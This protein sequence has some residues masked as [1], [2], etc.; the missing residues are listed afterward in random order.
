MTENTNR[1]VGSFTPRADNRIQPV[2]GWPLSLLGPLEAEH[3]GTLWRVMRRGPQWRHA[4]FAWLA[5]YAAESDAATICGAAERE[6]ADLIRA[7]FGAPAPDGLAGA[8][9]K[10]GFEPCSR[11]F[12]SNLREVLADRT[13]LG[14]RRAR[15]IKQVPILTE[16]MVD[17]IQTLNPH[18]CSPRVVA[19]YAHRSAAE[20]LNA[21]ARAVL[22]VCSGENWETIKLAVETEDRRGWPGWAAMKLARADRP[23]PE[24]LPTD[25]LPGARRVTPRNIEAI[26]AEFNNCLGGQ[27]AYRARLLSGRFAMVALAAPKVLVQMFLLADGTWVVTHVHLTKNADPSRALMEEVSG[28]LEPLGV[29]V[30]I[31]AP[32]PRQLEDLKQ[33]LSDWRCPTIELLDLIDD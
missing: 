31:L 29:R 21:E 16:G 14:L 13:P 32:M 4:Y 2:S 8:L 25:G 19:R 30:L 15:T 23:L 24:A 7:V 9:S 12:Y 18:L 22:Q 5:Q 27:A 3:P 20:R 10:L 33:V 17:A 11:P 1:C 6:S 28:L 26:G